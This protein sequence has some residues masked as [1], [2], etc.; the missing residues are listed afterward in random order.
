ME[1]TF[2]WLIALLIGLPIPALIAGFNKSGFHLK[3][4]FEQKTYKKNK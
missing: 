3:D 4:G 2:Q 1:E